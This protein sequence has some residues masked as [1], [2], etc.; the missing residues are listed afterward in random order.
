MF[1]NE[2]DL[3][4]HHRVYAFSASVPSCYTEHHRTTREIPC[5]WHFE[6]RCAEKAIDAVMKDKVKFIPGTL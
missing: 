1:R 5:R 3:I 4:F 2:F 6:A